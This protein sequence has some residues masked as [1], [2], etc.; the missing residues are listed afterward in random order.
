MNKVEKIKAEIERE[1]NLC[2][3]YSTLNLT[4]STRI[5]NNAQLTV[6][7]ELLS[8]IDSLE[9]P[10]SED[11]KKAARDASVCHSSKGDIFFSDSYKKFIAG[12]QWQKEQMMKNSDFINEAK[13]EDDIHKLFREKGKKVKLMIVEEE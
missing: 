8:F 13:W 11:L 9:E 12:A 3:K 6:L 2:N 7:K 4:E 1:I 10:I 5:G